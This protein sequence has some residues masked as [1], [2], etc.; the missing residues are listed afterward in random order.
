MKKI[1][2]VPHHVFEELVELIREEQKR[3]AEE[4]ERKEEEKKI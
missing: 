1:V 3:Q 2:S 4:K